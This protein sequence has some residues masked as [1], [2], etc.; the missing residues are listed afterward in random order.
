[1]EPKFK[2]SFIPKKPVATP[3]PSSASNRLAGINFFTLLAT[4]IFLAA[5]LFA[6]GLFMYKLTIEQRIEAQLATLD[7]VRQSFEP[8]FIAQAT[9]LNSRIEAA[10]SILESHIA[11]SAIFEILEES[12]LQTVA[13]SSF[14][15]RDNV[16]G[17]VV[18]EAKGEGDSFR[19]IVLQS[20]EYGRSGYMRDVLFGGLAPNERGNVNFTFEA[21]IDPRL[22]LYQRNLVPVR[23]DEAQS[24]QNNDERPAVENVSDEED[25][26]V[27]GNQQNQQ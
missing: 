9:R 23:Q 5:I 20:D 17:Q 18:V 7:K 15:F 6:A 14:V 12:T 13:L 26:G 11:P 16:E 10:E 25:L 2:T 27:F 22:V 21:V 4:V 24:G 1:M 3:G 19:S 8:N